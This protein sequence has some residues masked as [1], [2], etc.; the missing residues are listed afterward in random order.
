MLLNPDFKD[1]LSA[2]SAASS[3]LIFDESRY[4]L[5]QLGWRLLDDAGTT[6]S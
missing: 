6:T 1:M 5:C 2:L 4:P 3:V